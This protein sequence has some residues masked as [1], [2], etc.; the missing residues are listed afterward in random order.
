VK[1][2]LVAAIVATTTASDL[3][4]SRVMKAEVEVR[5]FGPA[6]L[7][8]RLGHLLAQPQLPAAIA[9]MA[10]S[11][12]AFLTLL[13]MAELSFAVPATAASYVLETMLARMLLHERVQAERWA[14]A[15]LVAGGVALL[16]GS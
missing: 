5:D 14:G 16:A 3:L 15:M 7:G 10:V 11:F 6:R 12:F 8:K 2:A 9:C 13:S 4:Q 1:W